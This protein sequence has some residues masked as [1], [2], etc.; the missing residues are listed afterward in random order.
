MTDGQFANFT[1]AKERPPSNTFTNTRT[2]KIGVMISEKT[3][4]GEFTGRSV[5]RFDR[6][7]R[8]IHQAAHLICSMRLKIWA[9]GG[10]DNKGFIGTEQVAGRA[11]G[12]G[13]KGVPDIK[14]INP[15][16]KLE[17]SDLYTGRLAVKISG[18]QSGG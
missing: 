13:L 11:T 5:A 18:E 9:K 6:T 16:R 1:V 4:V 7:G 8:T 12:K 17:H 15:K 14:W 10:D 2:G 3:A